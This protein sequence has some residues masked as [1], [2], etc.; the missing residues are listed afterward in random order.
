VAAMRGP[1]PTRWN[2]IRTSR[3]LERVRKGAE[4]L[5]RKRRALV[6]EIFGL[7][8][9]ALADRTRLTERAASAYPALLRVLAARGGAEM[10]ALGWPTRDPEL[11]MELHETWGVRIAEVV[12]APELRRTP[13]GRGVAPAATGPEV[14]EA[15]DEFEDFAAL[16]LEAAS[17][18]TQIR[19]LAR[20]L[21]RTS[22]QVNTLEQRVEP[23]LERQ[24]VEI[25]RTLEER[26]REDHL[27][28]RRLS[29]SR[30]GPGAPPGGRGPVSPSD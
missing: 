28:L 15:A 27:R 29:R 17:R 4:L 25:R 26:E 6:S 5:G 16:L 13:A 8:R 1:A 18:E 10:R 30:R 23:E 3:R 24:A 12:E 14:A 21:A 7:A 20:A 11:E 2:L 9:P 19:R 22:R